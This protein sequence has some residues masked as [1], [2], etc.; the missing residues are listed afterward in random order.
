MSTSQATAKAVS[1]VERSLQIPEGVKLE[2]GG[3]AVTVTGPKGTLSKDL[4]HLPITMELSGGRLRIYEEWPRKREI[5]MVGT[6][7][8]HV[9]NMITGVTKG[10]AYG[11]KVVYAHFPITVKVQKGRLMIENFTGEKTPRSAPILPDVEVKVEG[12]TITVEGLDKERVSQTAANIQSATR[13]K[14]KDQRVFL[15]GIYVETTSGA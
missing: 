9:R 5:A 3:R 7:A 2:L 15:D 4:S 13:I 14:E 12:D 11:L 10:Y 6:A 1:I 8:A